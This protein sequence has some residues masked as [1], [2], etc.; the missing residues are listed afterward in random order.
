MLPNPRNPLVGHI[1][2]FETGK[3][4]RVSIRNPTSQSH[5]VGP[6]G[7]QI[8]LSIRRFNGELPTGRLQLIAG[9]SDECTEDILAEQ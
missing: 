3:F 7:I 4:L 9:P 8:K 6:E 5:T 1:D 2:P